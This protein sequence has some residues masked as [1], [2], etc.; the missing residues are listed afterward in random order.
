MPHVD[1]KI[2]DFNNV[3]VVEGYSDLRFYAEILEELGKNEEVF[4]KLLTDKTGLYTKLETLISPGFLKN[5]AKIGFIFDADNDPN[6][7]R[8]N[9]ENALRT[10]T[11]QN[12][13]DTNWTHGQ[14]NIGLLIVPGGARPGEIET[15][16]WNSWANDPNNK[17]QK[18]CVEAYTNCMKN[19]GKTAHSPDKGLI[20]ALLA[21]L[22]DEDPRLGPGARDNVFDLARP[23]LSTL[24]TF[25][26]GF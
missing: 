2:E 14:P 24:R 16:V 25:L 8:L 20:G 15:L 18:Q 12:V 3:L 13:V 6:Q 4:I 23:E 17:Q 11:G 22:S 21:I 9:I 7:T 10:L 1:R 5:K 26:A 19:A